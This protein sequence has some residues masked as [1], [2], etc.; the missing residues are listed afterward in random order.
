LLRYTFPGPKTLRSGLLLAAVAAALA[1]LTMSSAAMAA[2]APVATT[3]P[4]TS[5]SLNAASCTMSFDCA[6]GGRYTTASGTTGAGVNLLASAPKLGDY[7]FGA[8]ATDING[9]ACTGTTASSCTAVGRGGSG[10][11]FATGSGTTEPSGAASSQLRAL[12]CDDSLYCVAVGDYVDSAGLTRGYGIVRTTASSS[13]SVAFTYAQTTG[14][15]PEYFAPHFTGV[16]CA[17]SSPVCYV[18][19]TIDVLP[20]ATTG[21]TIKKFTRSTGALSTLNITAPADMGGLARLNGIS[22]YASTAGDWCAAVGS[23]HTR[24]GTVVSSTVSPLYLQVTTAGS[25]SPISGTPAAPAGATVTQLNGVAC[26]STSR[27]HVVGD[28]NASGTTQP[29]RG[30]LAT[31][32]VDGPS[33]GIASG[34]ARGTGC[35]PSGPCYDVGTGTTASGAQVGITVTSTL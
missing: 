23:Y 2:W 13:W 4:S 7:T 29:Y 21:I 16:S 27:C 15:H 24:I 3:V 14:G 32:A 6:E 26:V 1:T 12:S 11:A 18:V 10:H 5:S 22:C 19:G 33:P 17:T 31:G 28:S 20:T 9:I 25:A 34:S 35:L 30:T 8:A